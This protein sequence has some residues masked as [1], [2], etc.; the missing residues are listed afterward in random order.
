MEILLRIFVLHIYPMPEPSFHVLLLSSWYPSRVHRTLGNFVERHARAIALKHK[1]T[2]LYLSSDPTI[3]STEIDIREEYGMEV[4]RVY[5]RPGTFRPRDHYRALG[6]GIDALRQHGMPKPDFIHCNVMFPAAMQAIVLQRRFGVPVIYSEHWTGFH[7]SQDLGIGLAGRLMLKHAGHT[8]A[9]ICPVSDH[10]GK[11]MQSWGIKGRY[12]TVPN[13]VD[14]ELFRIGDKNGMRFRFLHVSSLVD[15]HKNISGMLRAAKS[16]LAQDSEMEFWFVGDGDTR[17]HENYARELGLP[18]ENLKFLGEQ[19]LDEIARLM[20]EVNAFLMFSFYENLPCVILEAF[21]S[22][23]PVISSDTGGIREHLDPSRGIL[24]TNGD[25][26]ELSRA[27]LQIKRGYHDFDMQE[28]REYALARF[29]PQ[30][31]AESYTA[32]YQQ[33]IS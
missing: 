14:T 3:E 33:M 24:V 9:F 4:C 21:A 27:I 8:A 20:S 2:V 26:G 29:S 22:G 17:P 7:R 28:L 25:E 32:L 23:L 11:A 12:H 16:A 30:R 5:F 13:V 31:I 18:P 1:V 15:E 19:P 10:L 6:N